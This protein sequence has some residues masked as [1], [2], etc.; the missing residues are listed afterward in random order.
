MDKE[1]VKEYVKRKRWTIK[2]KKVQKPFH[3]S[4]KLFV[5]IDP[6]T[7]KIVKFFKTIREL[8]HATNRKN[9]QPLMYKYLRNDLGKSGS[10]LICGW[11]MVQYEEE[12]A[13]DK[14]MEE[15]QE[16]I[17][18]KAI[19]KILMMQLQRIRDNLISFTQGDKET[20]FKFLANTESPNTNDIN[21]KIQL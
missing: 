6:N 12:E 3:D 1:N 19:D 14:S 21:L 10:P 8:E 11:I 5:A 7:Y 16:L 17:K 9:L 13:E 20:I 15:F 2:A 18:R 4:G